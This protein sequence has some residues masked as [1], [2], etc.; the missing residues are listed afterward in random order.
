MCNLPFA[1]GVLCPACWGTRVQY[2]DWDNILQVAED[3]TLDASQPRR[4]CREYVC[5]NPECKFSWTVP[6]SEIIEAA[7][8]E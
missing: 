7:A 3:V 1:D 6:L 8:P 4:N 5:A 2:T